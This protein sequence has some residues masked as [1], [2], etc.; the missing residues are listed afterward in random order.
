MIF[1]LPR[2]LL[3]LC[4]FRSLATTAVIKSRLNAP[5]SAFIVT[6]VIVASPDPRLI[7]SEERTGGQPLFSEG[8]NVLSS[9]VA[10]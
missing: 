10:I 3:S 4:V 1:G 9:T 8:S 5:L 2:P 7:T 6:L